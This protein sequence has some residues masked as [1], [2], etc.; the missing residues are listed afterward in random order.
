MDERPFHGCP[1]TASHFG[2]PA[3]PSGGIA[4]HTVSA[5]SEAGTV[6]SEAV[7][8]VPPAPVP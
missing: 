1:R 8:V 7:H 5:H 4:F 2:A 3:I 6:L